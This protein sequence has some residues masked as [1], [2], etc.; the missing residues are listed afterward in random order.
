MNNKNTIDETTNAETKRITICGIE[1]PTDFPRGF[2]LA[3]Q[4][5]YEAAAAEHNLNEVRE[6]FQ[7]QA[8]QG[9]LERQ[10]A[11][12]EVIKKA[13]AALEK[14][15]EDL[16]A[17]DE[18]NLDAIEQAELLL[19]KKKDEETQKTLEAAAEQLAAT[20][21]HEARMEALLKTV[22]T[23]NLQTV[24]ALLKMHGIS[25]PAFSEF[26]DAATADDYEAASEVIEAG[27]AGASPLARYVS[28]SSR[29]SRK[30]RSVLN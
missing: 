4:K 7:L 23:V 2:R 17:A 1:L 25:V 14:R 10:D 12:L 30:T 15:V 22:D 8:A 5:L 18:L 13:V 27:G 3:E 29:H 19:A 9:N 11:N 20:R 28:R 26:Q 21:A 6:D 16:Y 24:H